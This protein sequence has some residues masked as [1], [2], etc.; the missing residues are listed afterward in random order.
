MAQ[1]YKEVQAILIVHDLVIINLKLTILNN[2]YASVYVIIHHHQNDAMLCKRSFLPNGWFHFGF[3]HQDF[4]D[5]TCAL[6]FST[7]MS[8][9]F[10]LNL[11]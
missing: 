4:A 2:A 9:S 8:C 7:F 5:E 1:F 11:H 10:D 6:C 3:C